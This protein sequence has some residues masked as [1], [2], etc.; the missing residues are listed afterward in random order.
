MRV[1]YTLDILVKYRKFYNISP[2]YQRFYRFLADFFANR[3]SVGKIV[4]IPVDIRYFGDISV[5]ISDFL[6]L[7]ND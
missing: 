5:D 1:R 6:F 3:L 7:E 4:S 2:K